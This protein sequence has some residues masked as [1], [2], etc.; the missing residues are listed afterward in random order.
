LTVIV[1]KS[2]RQVSASSCWGGPIAIEYEARHPERVNPSYLYSAN[3]LCGC[4]PKGK[5]PHRH[6]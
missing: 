5:R 6:L 2:T 4:A 1:S 3:A